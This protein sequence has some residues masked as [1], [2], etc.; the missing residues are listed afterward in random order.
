VWDLFYDADSVRAMLTKKIQEESMRTYLFTY[1]NV[2]DSISIVSTGYVLC[3]LRP[4][5]LG[6]PQE[7]ITISLP[8]ARA[9]RDVRA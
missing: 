9:G 1:S 6:T 3:M 2:Y 5:G 8:A 4:V 7:E